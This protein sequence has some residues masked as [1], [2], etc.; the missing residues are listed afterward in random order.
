M[1]SACTWF[2]DP[3]HQRL[4]DDC[5]EKAVLVTVNDSLVSGVSVTK[6]KVKAIVE[7]VVFQFS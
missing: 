6:E 1:F 5:F 3:L 7:K 4:K 2:D